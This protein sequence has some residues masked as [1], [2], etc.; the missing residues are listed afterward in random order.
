MHILNS[1]PSS[2]SALALK[3]ML[4]ESAEFEV[5]GEATNAGDYSPWRSLI[6]Q[7]C[8]DRLG[9]AGPI[10]RRSDT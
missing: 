8:A 4:Q 6:R 2:S 9:A 5:A 10:D 7:T 1:R 3:T